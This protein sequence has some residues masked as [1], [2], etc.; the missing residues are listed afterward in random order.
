MLVK[1]KQHPLSILK[2]ANCTQIS[3]KWA[4]RLLNIFGSLKSLNA[5]L[6]STIV[7]DSN[8]GSMSSQLEELILN[9]PT[10][11]TDRGLQMIGRRNGGMLN[12]LQLEA[13]TRISDSGLSYV[14]KLPLQTVSIKAC[15]AITCTGTFVFWCQYRCTVF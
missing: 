12:Y 1:V 8:C 4:E 5:S 2:I 11:L 13:C 10:G 3:S 15:P 6:S 9:E 14:S 7:T